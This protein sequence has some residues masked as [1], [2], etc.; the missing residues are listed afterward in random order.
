M[1]RK[2]LTFI[3]S[4]IVLLE[5][6]ILPVYADGMWQKEEQGW[7]Y[8][9][10]SGEKVQGSAEVIN[11]SIYGFDEKGQMLTGWVHKKLQLVNP[12]NNTIIPSVE[13]R[14]YYFSP[15]TG[16]ALTDWQQLDNKWY[17]FN[18]N[19]AMLVNTVTPDG[20]YVDQNGIWDPDFDSSNRAAI[21]NSEVTQVPLDEDL[22][23]EIVDLVNKERRRA[24]LSK[25]RVDEKLMNAAAIRT[26]EITG[27]FDHIRPDGRS[28]TTIFDDVG[29]EWHAIAENIAYQYSDSAESVMN[30]WMKSGAHNKNILN[31][32]YT[33]IGVGTYSD[34]YTRYWVQLFVK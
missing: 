1:N 33:S 29:I 23:A 13:A 34:G 32:A 18:H 22:I 12:A 6:F 26:Q 30:G 15:G 8:Y 27:I 14:W 24:G 31:P 10:E 3:V 11:G 7:V 25:L 9:R 16:I 28:Y 4:V 20:R 21:H 2:V 5:Q 17:Y 19:G